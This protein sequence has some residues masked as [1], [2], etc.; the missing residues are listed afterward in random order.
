MTAEI[1]VFISNYTLVDPEIYELWIEGQTATEAV[2]TL[3][4]RG[5]GQETGASLELIA[6]DVLDHYRTYSLLEK[7]LINPNKLQEQL[8][9]QIEPLTRQL[10]IEKYYD[11]DDAVI[12]ELLGKKLSSKH[13][14]DLDE[15]AERTGVP[16]KSCRRQFDNVKRIFKMVEEMPGLLVQNIQNLFY[17]PE[18]LARK[19]ACIVFVGCIRFETTKR[20]LQHLTFPCWK[21]CA[22]VIMDQWTYKQ[23]G[24]EYYETEM[25]KEF[26]LELRELKVLG[27]KEKEHK[28][29]V[30]TCVKSTMLQKNFIDLDMNFRT[31]SRMILLLS[32]TLHRSRDMRNFFVELA[33]FID[34]WKQS[35]LNYQDM[36]QFLQ[37]YSQTALEIDVFREPGLK[38]AWEKYMKVISEC[39]LTMYKNI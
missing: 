29:L 5:L 4:Q 6:S 7:L 39:I 38:T 25:D 34:L 23:T 2:A 35:H 27:D 9:F 30:C 28:H 1:D 12:R 16:L 20:K 22:E 31:Y 19:Y 15:V 33:Q 26:L 24:P 37:A 21:K 17:L 18:E 8:A 10:L 13:R 14:K 36:E 11:F 3:N 32:S